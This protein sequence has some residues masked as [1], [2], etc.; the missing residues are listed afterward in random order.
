MRK[1]TPEE[2]KKGIRCYIDG[3]PQYGDAVQNFLSRKAPSFTAWCKRNGIETEADFRKRMQ[4]QRR[5]NET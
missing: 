3:V 1:R 5:S 4:K 2:E